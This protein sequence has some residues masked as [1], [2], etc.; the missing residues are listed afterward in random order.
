MSDSLTVSILLALLFG[1]IIG[2]LTDLF[3]ATGLLQSRKALA[4]ERA[5]NERLRE[6]IFNSGAEKES[7]RD[8]S[9]NEAICYRAHF[10]S[11]SGSL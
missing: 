1:V 4:N 7:E 2:R 8:G 6:I 5:E 11:D 9:G 10:P 3:G